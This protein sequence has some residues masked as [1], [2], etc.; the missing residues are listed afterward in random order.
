MQ[1]SMIDLIVCDYYVAE[2]VVIVYVKDFGH[3]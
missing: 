2:I 3:A 1:Y